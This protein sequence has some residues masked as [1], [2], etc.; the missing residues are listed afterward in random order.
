[1]PI[2]LV[3]P[4]QAQQPENTLKPSALLPIE[5]YGDHALPTDVVKSATPRW[6]VIPKK[7]GM[8]S[9]MFLAMPVH[10]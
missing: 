9:I 4:A 3:V 1:M 10:F 5:K 8:V 7:V 6:N 2:S